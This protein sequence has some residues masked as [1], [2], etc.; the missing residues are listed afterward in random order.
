MSEKYT[1]AELRNVSLSFDRAEIRDL[2]AKNSQGVYDVLTHMQVWNIDKNTQAC[3]A[4]KNYSVIQ[5]EHAA[6]CVIDAIT[7]L[8]ITS[9]AQVKMDKHRVQIDFDF[10]DAVIKLND[11]GEQFSSGLRIVS[12]YSQVMGL[13]IYARVTRLACSNGMLVTDLVK[14]RRIKYGEEM[15]IALEG[16][17]DKIIKEIITNDSLLS[18]MVSHCIKDSIEWQSLQ[19][20]VKALFR[21]PRHVRKIIARLDRNKKCHSRW[22]LYNA[23]THYCTNDERIKPT[24]DHW[25]QEKANLV[26][27]T[28][29]SE[30]T[31]QLVKTEKPDTQDFLLDR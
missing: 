27:K 31:E 17:I 15:T 23:V 28:P 25:L 8:N 7:A 30:L 29:F 19:L 20:L 3:I 1:L 12:D 24:I 13:V 18:D 14:K 4:T 26:L 6:N 5:H 22:D 11:V 21:K 16:I 10:P 9:R 2:I